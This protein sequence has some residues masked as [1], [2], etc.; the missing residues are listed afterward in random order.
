M[1]HYVHPTKSG[2]VT[3]QFHSKELSKVVEKSIRKQAGID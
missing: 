2:K 1:M 3:I